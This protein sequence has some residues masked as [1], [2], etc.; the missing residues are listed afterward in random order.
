[1]SETQK[2]QGVTFKHAVQKESKGGMASLLRISFSA[3]DKDGEWCTTSPKVY[4]YAKDVFEENEVFDVEVAVSDRPQKHIIRVVK[5]AQS[6]S[7]P[8][9]PAGTDKSAPVAST[10]SAKPAA[11]KPYV[12]TTNKYNDTAVSKSIERQTILNAT[13]RSLEALAGTVSPTNVE[14]VASKLIALYD[15]YINS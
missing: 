10:V 9:E 14:E 4:A 5:A 2:Y 1:M 12:P 3:D 13:A 11:T 6:G 8:A 15:K 7:A